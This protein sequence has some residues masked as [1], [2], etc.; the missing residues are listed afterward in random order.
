MS[1]AS[2]PVARSGLKRRA[3]GRSKRCCSGADW[4]HHPP[5]RA[6]AR[7][8]IWGTV[9][10]ARQRHCADSGFVPHVV[11]TC[12]EHPA[13]LETLAAYAA[14]GLL[15]YTA[16]PVDGE[17]LVSVADVAAALTTDTV[18]LTVMHSNN[19]VGSIQP[20]AQLAVLARER[21]VLMH[22]DAAQSI[23]KVAVD[24][25]RLG[26]DLLT[27]VRVIFV[28]HVAAYSSWLLG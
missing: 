7:R 27:I 26:V 1:G 16:V 25:R 21:S 4:R 15:T 23:G 20:I 6:A 24:V 8:A 17:G 13:V 9:Q 11:T 22:C 10:V 14:Q 28:F 3:A 5:L 12:I 18:L 2:K 19:E